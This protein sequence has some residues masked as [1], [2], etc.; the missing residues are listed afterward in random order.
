MIGMPSLTQLLPRSSSKSASSI[1]PLQMLLY[2]TDINARYRGLEPVPQIVDAASE[3][4]NEKLDIFEKILGKQKYMGGDEFSLADI[5]YLPYTQKLFEA[6]DGA[7][8]TSRPNVNAWWERVSTR[9]SWKKVYAPLP[10]A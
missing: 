7:F 6:G 5:F 4:F 10:S 8:I 9:D 2:H 1:A 3:K